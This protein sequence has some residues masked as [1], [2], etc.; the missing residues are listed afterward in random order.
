MVADS[1]IRAL[2]GVLGEGN[3]S[4][5]EPRF[6]GNEQRFVRECGAST[7]V[8]S[9]GAYVDRFEKDPAAYTGAYRAVAVVNGIAA[10]QEA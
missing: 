7:Y 8:S 2:R 5:R 6:A 1:V 3:F 4:L 9:V 10:L